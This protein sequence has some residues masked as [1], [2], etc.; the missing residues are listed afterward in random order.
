MTAVPTTLRLP[1]T[2]RSFPIVTS[3]GR[4]TVTVPLDSVTVTSFAVP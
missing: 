1:L 3:S 2:V 4:A